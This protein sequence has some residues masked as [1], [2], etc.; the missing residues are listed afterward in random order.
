MFNRVPLASC[1]LVAVGNNSSK[2]TSP[3]RIFMMFC[4]L[5]L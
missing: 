5:N 3:F 4:F 2:K 1:A